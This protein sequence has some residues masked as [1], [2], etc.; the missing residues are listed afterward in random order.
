MKIR[1]IRSILQMLVVAFVATLA[2]G[3]AFSKTKTHVSFLPRVSQPLASSAKASLEVADFKDSRPVGDKTFLVHKKNGYGQ[4]TSGAFVA[5]K[6]IADIFR[7][8]VV[9]SLKKNN[10]Q[11]PASSG[12]YVLNGEIQDFDF[13]VITGFWKAS[14]KPKL[15]VRFDL[16]EKSTGNSV[17]RDSYIGR[18]TIETAWG[19]SET[20]VQ[21]FNESANDAVRQLVSDESFRKIFEKGEISAR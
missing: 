9:E 15:Q 4:T 12:K 20:I 16:M 11:L 19:T 13:D 2:T 10:F 18:A 1:S 17:W 14:V 6:P 21:L 5:Q 8:G 3:C 7:D